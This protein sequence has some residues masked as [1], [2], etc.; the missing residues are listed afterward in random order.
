VR[1][2]VAQVLELVHRGGVDKDTALVAQA[3][4]SLESLLQREEW[5]ETALSRAEAAYQMGLVRLTLGDDQAASH[6]FAACLE[7]AASGVT[8]A[9]A[10]QALVELLH[11]QG[12]PAS[13]A[14]ALSG[15][16]GDARV[17]ENAGE[18]IGHLVGAARITWHDLH[19]P[20][21]AASLLE[22]ALG[23][24]P[25]NENVLT[26]LERLALQTGHPEGVIAILHRHLRETR[27]DQGKA[28]LR[29][30][31]RLLVEAGNQQAEAKEACGVLLD[32][33]P[34]DEE[35]VFYLARLGWEAGERVE[36][37]AG[38]RSSTAAHT[39]SLAQLAEAH[40]R[41]AE[42]DFAAGELEEAERHLMLG[43]AIEPRGARI[44]VLAEVLHALG[45]DE[46]LRDLVAARETALSDQRERRQ[47]RLSL[48][49]AAERKQSGRRGAARPHGLHL[50]TPV[51]PRGAGRVA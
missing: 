31:I 19:A 13:V 39:L 46:Q 47:I 2:E 24:A 4:A 50:S 11:R 38:Y 37:S 28:V 49:A 18:K 7:G 17:P 32:L 43:L 6:W 27:P 30:L 44:D 42:L 35:A 9:A 1:D 14:Q 15:W 25:A 21:Q 51:A 48:A 10:W 5:P 40:L 29:V 12:D 45:H 22:S 16:A 34:G 20:D 33:C 3:A 26:E 23:L 36:A 8:A 41:V